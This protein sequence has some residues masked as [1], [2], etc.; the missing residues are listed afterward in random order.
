MSP[1]KILN[2]C[3]LLRELPTCTSILRGRIAPFVHCFP[4]HLMSRWDRLWDPTEGSSLCLASHMAHVA[5]VQ[6]DIGLSFFEGEAGW[7]ISQR[8]EGQGPEPSSPYDTSSSRVVVGMRKTDLTQGQED[9]GRGTRVPNTTICK[10]TASCYL[11]R[12]SGRISMYCQGL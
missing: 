11:P 2:V 9:E 10:L 5:V 6:F 1:V 12:L 4:S 3:P 7:L 8:P